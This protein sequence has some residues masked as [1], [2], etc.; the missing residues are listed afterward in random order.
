M[1]ATDVLLLLILVVLGYLSLVARSIS[2][3]IARISSMSHYQQTAPYT[4]SPKAAKAP[5]AKKAA[6]TP[7]I[8]PSEFVSISDIDEDTAMEAIEKWG[9]S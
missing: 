3:A 5:F 8:K 6:P 9:Q 4:A 1:T 2:D 7:T